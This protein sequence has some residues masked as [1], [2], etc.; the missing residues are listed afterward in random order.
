MDKNEKNNFFGIFEKGILL[1]L[2]TV[3][4]SNK[5]KLETKIKEKHSAHNYPYLSKELLTYLGF[6]RDRKLSDI[7]VCK[8]YDLGSTV[9]DWYS[10]NPRNSKPLLE[11]FKKNIIGLDPKL[12]KQIEKVLQEKKIISYCYIFEASIFDEYVALKEQVFGELLAEKSAEQLC[13]NLVDSFKVLETVFLLAF[14]VYRGY[15]IEAGLQPIYIENFKF[16]K[17]LSPKFDI[18]N[19]PILLSSSNYY[20]PYCDVVIKSIVNNSNYNSNYDIIILEQDI[21]EENK[22]VLKQNEKSNISIRFLDPRA[23]Y[24]DTP[25]F[26][27]AV[28]EFGVTR[29]APILSYRA[30]CPYFLQQ[31]DK[32]IWL[33]CD[34]IVRKDLNEL[35]SIDLENNY[36]GMVR[37]LAIMGFLNGSDKKLGEY[38]FKSCSMI[39]P[40][41]Y[42]NA[43]VVLLNLNLIR[44]EIPFDTFT[45]ACLERKHAIPEQD[46]INALWEGRVKH[47]DMR[48]NVFTFGS[49]PSW[50]LGFVPVSFLQVYKDALKDPWV[51]HYVG[52]SKPWDDLAVRMSHVFWEEARKSPFYE[53]M[54]NRKMS[55]TSET[56]TS[57]ISKA[58]R[59]VTKLLP[60]HSRRRQ[61]VK[62][63]YR[64]LVR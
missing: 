4:H 24:F 11:K 17:P 10:R 19:V 45:K 52:P 51:I 62:K 20:V 59:A 63:I 29:F 1:D 32:V 26:Y 6:F 14:V 9:Q 7:H 5:K 16:F 35:Y 53:E 2:D 22:K 38:Y 47:I 48:W 58:E 8:S 49:D 50:G 31:Y 23:F 46:T 36:A 27:K 61:F 39:N 18:N 56:S 40:Y 15:D 21:T 30:F 33:D 3:E 13:I 25:E 34:L 64:F 28:E 60:L 37:D 54:L 57:V 55:V 12:K 44:K 42:S 43:G 41:M